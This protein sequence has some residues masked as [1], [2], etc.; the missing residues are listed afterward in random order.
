MNEEEIKLKE[1]IEEVDDDDNDDN[2]D[3]KMGR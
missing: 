1:D 3:L 2:N